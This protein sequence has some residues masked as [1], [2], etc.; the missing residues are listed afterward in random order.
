MNER[1]ADRLL[2]AYDE[3]GR[4]QVFYSANGAQTASERLNATPEWDWTPAPS[5]G[6]PGV[7]TCMFPLALG[8]P[9]RLTSEGKE[10][11]H[12]LIRDP[13]QVRDYAAPEVRSGRTGEVLRNLGQ[14]VAGLGPDEFVREPDIQSPLGVV[15]LMWGER[16]YSDLIE[17]PGEVHVLLDKVTDFIIA[18][19]REV[20][21]TAGPRLNS[22]GFPP[23]WDGPAGTM[24]ADDTMSLVSPAMHREF[25]IPYLNRIATACGPLH[26]HSCTWRRHHFRNIHEIGPVRSYNWNPGNSDDPDA[27]IGEFSG[28]A[29]LAP[30]I[31]LDMHK[32]T[33]VLKWQPGLADESYLLEYMLDCLRPNST[34]YFWF[35]N[36]VQHRTAIERMHQLLDTRGWT[37]A[38]PLNRPG[39][40]RDTRLGLVVPLG[41][42]PVV[43]V[44]V[45]LAIIVV[46]DRAPGPA[47]QEH[48]AVFEDT[49]VNLQPAE[50]LEVLAD[51]ARWHLA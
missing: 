28:C 7:S 46:N 19:I 25:S 41:P 23:V 27:I 35:S 12:P 21:R 14:V 4:R 3:P 1:M 47:E 43:V 24:V 34:L 50:V 9:P 18:F 22:A 45:S 29:V 13:A 42:C 44:V 6:V 10:W 36:V 17:H 30:H 11:V 39:R 49:P 2:E 31:C 26:Y 15:E 37:P 48:A 32:D 8:C 16:L 20:K 40:H 51:H 33:D 5:R 38:R